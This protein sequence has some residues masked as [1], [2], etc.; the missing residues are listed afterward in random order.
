MGFK[1]CEA[2]HCVWKK[3]GLVIIVY[4]DDCLI[5]GNSKDEVDKI[6]EELGKRFDITD[7]VTNAEEYLGVKIN[8]NKD[9]SFRMYQ[10]HLM[11]RI[12]HTIPG[13]ENANEHLILASISITLT[14]DKNEPGRK[15]TWEYRL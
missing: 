9:G 7:E 2:D 14:A 5:F 6:V 8:L 3:D 1:Q 15:E 10:P 11:Q 13:M 12:I 4:V